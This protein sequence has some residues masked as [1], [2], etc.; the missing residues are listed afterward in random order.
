M[1]TNVILTSGGVVTL[2]L[3]EDAPMA[4]TAFP[5][6]YYHASEPTGRIFASQDELDAAGP[7]WVQSPADIHEPPPPAPEAPS[8]TP[9]SSRR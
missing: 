4:E 8:H 1:P 5:R 6:I 9:R 2:P 3:P 7:G